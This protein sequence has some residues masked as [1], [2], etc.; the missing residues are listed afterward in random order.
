MFKLCSYINSYTCLF[1]NFPGFS[2]KTDLYIPIFYSHIPIQIHDIT[3]KE[4][5]CPKIFLVSALTST[6][7]VSLTAQ[8]KKQNNNIHS[9]MHMPILLYVK[10]FQATILVFVHITND[11]VYLEY[12]IGLTDS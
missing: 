1:I 2:L 4:S 10:F 5:F 3:I 9:L 11:S 6:A 7:G 8:I 12:F